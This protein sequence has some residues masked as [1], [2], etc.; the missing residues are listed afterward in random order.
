MSESTEPEIDPGQAALQEMVV[1]LS[2]RFD[3]L[4]AERLETGAQE[5]GEFAFLG[6]DV[7]VM[8]QEELL[9]IS[10]YARFLFIKIGILTFFLDQ[11]AQKTGFIPEEGVTTQQMGAAAFKGADTWS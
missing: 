3:N 5:Y 2:A 4:T 9:D 1:A 8:L 10:N 6:N 11:Q 7:A